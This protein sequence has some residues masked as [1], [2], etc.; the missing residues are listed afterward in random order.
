MQ[1]E[2]ETSCVHHFKYV[3]SQKDCAPC[4]HYF[5]SDFL[6]FRAFRDGPVPAARHAQP[7]LNILILHCF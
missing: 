1:L 6:L 3:G 5:C 4:K 7:Q 2:V